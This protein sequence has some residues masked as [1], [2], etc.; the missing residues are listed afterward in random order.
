MVNWAIFFN[1]AQ[2]KMTT[3]ELSSMDYEEALL[4]YETLLSQKQEEFNR[5]EELN[6]VQ[7]VAR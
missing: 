5:L 3:K 2:V 1:Q 7:N 4:F 6:N